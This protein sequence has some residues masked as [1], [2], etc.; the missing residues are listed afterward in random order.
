MVSLLP[1]FIA[2]YWYLFLIF[3]GFVYLFIKMYPAYKTSVYN[4]PLK[5]FLFYSKQIFTG[6][7]IIFAFVILGRGGFQL[8]PIGVIAAA[9]YTQPEYMG[10]VLNSPFTVVKTMG[11]NALHNPNYYDDEQVNQMYTPLHQ[12]N[13]QVHFKKKNVVVIILESFGKEYSGFLNDTVGY[14]PNLDSIMQK[15]LT[16]TQAFANGKRSIDALPAIISSIPCVMDNAFITSLYNSNRI[17]SIGEILK[18]EGYQTSFYHGGTNGTMGFDNFIKLAGISSYYGLNEY[19]DRAD[20][21][22]NWGIFDEPYLNYF[23]RQ[24]SQMQEPFFTSVFTLSSH[25]PYTI[26]EQYAGVFP[27]GSLVNQE[28]IAYA[29]F[30]LGKF[31]KQ[32]EKQSWYANTLFVLT[33]DHTAQADA[34]FYKTNVGKYAVPIVFYA[35]GDTLVRGLSDQ[36]C[37]QTD[38]FPSILDYLGYSKPFI[39]FGNSVFNEKS[40]QFAISY[41][42]GLYQ[43]IYDNYA[44]HFDGISMVAV[45]SISGN[46][47]LE[48]PVK[49]TIRT[50]IRKGKDILKAYIQQFN[51]RMEQNAMKESSTDLTK[52]N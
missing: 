41:T 30:A 9:R 25:H 17:Q 48:L 37:Q 5:P 12:F 40:P 49:D 26:P 31:F 28:S 14:T 33:A 50:P 35:P 20:F 46:Q 51:V 8:K 18:N 3:I 21:D 7:L 15:G 10:L 24:I 1:E 34:S 6:I 16:F 36:V 45:D 22:G 44:L 2:N 39:A 43:F 47:L 13:K 4:K 23:C 27:K 11:R 32:A 52:S 29:D 38:I 42:N 19:V